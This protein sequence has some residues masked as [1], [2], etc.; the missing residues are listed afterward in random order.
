VVND[1]PV[2]IDETDDAVAY[3]LIMP[4]LAV[5]P[6]ATVPEVHDIPGVTAVIAPPLIVTT[7]SKEVLLKQPLDMITR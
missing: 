5:A 1:A 4:L 7:D 2:P 6:N 3:Q